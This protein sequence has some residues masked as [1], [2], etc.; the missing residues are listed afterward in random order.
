MPLPRFDRLP[1]DR[2]AAILA[3]ARAEFAE[4]G[5]EAAS[6]NKIIEGAGISKTAAYHYFDGRNDLL[7]TVLDDVK[8]RLLS[9]LRVWVGTSTPE[10][11][12]AELRAGAARL[13]THLDE[14]PDDRALAPAAMDRPDDPAVTKWVSDVVRDGQALGIIRTDLDPALITAATA[15]LL[16]TLD[17]WALSGHPVG[18]AEWSLLAGLWGAR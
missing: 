8:A 3:V 17:G 10:R 11:F 9:A 12:W 2:R 18:D 6:Y 7:D 16:R 5:P 14:H 4:H 13:V 1:D 15:A